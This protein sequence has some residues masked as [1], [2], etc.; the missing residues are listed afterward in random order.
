MSTKNTEKEIENYTYWKEKW[1]I[2]YLKIEGPIDS[3]RLISYCRQIQNTSGRVF[4]LPSFLIFTNWSKFGKIK[5]A[6]ET[7]T[8]K[9]YY[10]ETVG[11]KIEI[12]KY[13]LKRE[14]HTCLIKYNA[15][16]VETGCISVE[17]RIII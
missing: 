9:S 4:P 12:K 1:K 3:E 13:I 16:F 6:A 11:K 2:E 15:N 17:F 8:W 7:S 14:I 5:R 10:N